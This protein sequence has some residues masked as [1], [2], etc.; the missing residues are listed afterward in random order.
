MMPV[1][2]ASALALTACTKLGGSS[3]ELWLKEDF[4]IEIGDLEFKLYDFNVTL[5]KTSTGEMESWPI[6]ALFSYSGY[7]Q[8]NELPKGFDFKVVGTLKPNAAAI[9]DQL[10]KAGNSLPYGSKYNCKVAF[11]KDKDMT[12]IKET[13]MFEHSDQTGTMRPDSFSKYL[14]K[15]TLTIVQYRN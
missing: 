13:V 11:Y 6:N 12:V 4:E 9:V 1:I 10:V 2:M 7:Q 3:K 8:I 5:Y 15:P 14:E